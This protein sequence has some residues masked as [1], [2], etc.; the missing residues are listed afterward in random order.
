MGVGKVHHLSRQ[1]ARRVA[2]RAQLLLQERPADLL[3]VVRRL[4]LLQLDP[5]SA[6][7]PSADLVA[8]S[9]LGSAY[10]PSDLRAA[11]DDRRLIELRALIRPAGD[12][13]LYRAAMDVWPGSGELR[14]WQL[15]LRDWVLAN[16]RCRRE[17][18]DRLEKAGPLPSREL[19]DLCEKPWP[20]TG[21]TNNKN[22]T[23]L[24]EFMTG[25]GEVAVAGRR[26]RDRLWDLAERVYQDVPVLPADEAVRVRGE[27]RVDPAYLDQSF[28]GRAALLSPFDRLVHDRA[29]AQEIFEFDYQLEMYQPVAKRRWGYYALPVLYGDRLVGKVDAKAD[30]KGGVLAVNAV[31]QDVPFTAAMTA[32]ID[33][34][35][36]SLADWLTLEPRRV[37]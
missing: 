1:D 37:G 13:A 9:R 22:V 26:G 27:W 29:R 23:Q 10:S 17:I 2:V 34:E 7:A 18:L 30:R 6:V 28:A 24:L 32:A 4:T 5:I 25:R 36:A 8:W 15:S 31:H 21:W 20:S 14:D 11:L 3:T 33:E 12:I 35:I 16:D 19:P